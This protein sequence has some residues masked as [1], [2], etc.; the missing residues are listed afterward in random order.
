MTAVVEKSGEELVD[1]SLGCQQGHLLIGLHSNEHV[2][3]MSRLCS[4]WGQRL[5][6]DRVPELL[7]HEGRASHMP[8]NC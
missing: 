4:H 5:V 6:P 7:H 3:R 1:S 8:Q 2:L